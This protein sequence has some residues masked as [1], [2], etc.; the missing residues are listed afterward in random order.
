MKR[1]LTI[2]SLALIILLPSACQE[3]VEKGIAQLKEEVTALESRVNQLNESIASL[4]SLISALEN[5]VFITNIRSTGSIYQIVFSNF[6]SLTLRN[7][8][9]GESPVV[10]VQ[11]RV[12]TSGAGYFWT[13]R[14][15]GKTEVLGSATGFPPQL[16]IENGSWQ[17]SLDRGISWTDC[18]WGPARGET[19]TSLFS[20]I[21]T[22]D[23]YSVTFTL[24]DGTKFKLP[25]KQAFD[26]LSATCDSLNRSFKTYT[27]IINATDSS[28]FVKSVSEFEEGGDTGYRIALENGETITIRNGRS[29]RDSVLLSARAYTDG[30]YYWV[31]RSRSSEEYQWLRYQGKMICVTLEDVTPIIGV[32]DSLG[33]LYFTVAYAG[34]SA[35]KMRD[36]SGRAVPATGQV[37]LDF[38]TGADLSESTF[39]TL[40]MSDGNTFRLPRTRGHIPSMSISL[41]S[42]YLE[43][44][45]RYTFQLLVFMKDTLPSTTPYTTYESYKEA[46]GISFDAIAIDDGY[47]EPPV[48][49]SG[50]F[51]Y[52][53]LEAPESGVEYTVIYDIP[54]TT[55]PA[56]QW[57]TAYKSRFALFLSWQN[58]TIMKVAE[59]N[60]AILAKSVSVSP[61]NLSIEVGQDSTLK[62]T[63]NPEFV[64]QKVTW[65]SNNTAVATVVDST[66]KVHAV[67]A[68]TCKIWATVG[69][70]TDTCTVTVTAAPAPGGGE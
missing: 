4:S 64:T 45:T 3:E 58:K 28:I 38:F 52:R 2:L 42:D 46:S 54:F 41:R 35:E 23:P 66:G 55:G 27:D 63:T 40:T 37:V 67:A 17:F 49:F 26:E 7:G 20:G 24:V 29:S 22:S 33:Q 19:G 61:K 34:G 36:T 43:S 69:R 13:V 14:L 12:T 8:T 25:T 16:R 44:D 48:A 53:V 21:D 59:F 32:T 51:S 5:N 10:G 60:R 57:N 39:V 15:G 31:Y 56:S 18:G 11:Y 70:L 62:V 65:T 6:T 68:G 9:D 30:K 50:G 1:Y 47:A